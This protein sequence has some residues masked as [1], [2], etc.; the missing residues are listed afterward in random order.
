MGFGFWQDVARF[1]D[2]G[3]WKEY[4]YLILEGLWKDFERSLEGAGQVLA[5]FFGGGRVLG[6]FWQ[7]V[8]GSGNLEGLLK[9]CMSIWKDFDRILGYGSWQEFERIL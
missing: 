9:G 1:S 5:M 6:R 3:F 2:D 4:W 7:G 8:E